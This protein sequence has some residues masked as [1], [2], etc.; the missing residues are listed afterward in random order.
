MFDYFRRVTSY[1]ARIKGKSEG[2]KSGNHAILGGTMKGMGWRAGYEAGYDPGPYVTSAIVSKH[3]QSDANYAMS[4]VR[5]AREDALEFH[6]RMAMAL[7]ALSPKLHSD[8]VCEAKAHSIP[9]FGYSMNEAFDA[10]QFVDVTQPHE[11]DTLCFPHIIYTYDG[12][13]NELHRDND[14]NVW[15]SGIFAALDAA[16]GHLLENHDTMG[17]HLY[18]ASYEFYSTLFLATES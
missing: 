2:G 13:V 14:E 1:K 15:A 3:I 12:F 18:N 5:H 10:L 11:E 7:Y 9:M 16:T 6:R 8:R 4:H 17:Y